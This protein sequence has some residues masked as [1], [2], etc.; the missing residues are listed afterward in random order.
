MTTNICMKEGGGGEGVGKKGVGHMLFPCK[1][2]VGRVSPYSGEG[3]DCITLIECQQYQ[4]KSR[5]LQRKSK[6][7]GK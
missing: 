7:L 1:S 3:G 2:G 4:T 5:K 6:Q